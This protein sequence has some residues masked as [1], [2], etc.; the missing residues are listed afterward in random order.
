MNEAPTSARTAPAAW[1]VV[2][3]ALVLFAF[4]CALGVWQVQRLAWKEGLLAT[5]EERIHRPPVPFRD[6]L[7][8]HDDGQDI[9]YLPVSV[10]GTFLHSGE[11]HFFATWKGASGYFVYTPL[12]R[13]DGSAVFVNRG[14]VPFDR[15]PAATRGEGQLAGKVTVTGLA[16][17]RL[18]QK[19]SSILPDNEPAKNIFYWKD[20]EAMAATAGLPDGTGIVPFFVDADDSPNP[21]GLPAGGVTLISMPNNHLQYAVTWFGLAAALAGVVGVWLLRIRREDRPRRP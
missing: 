16:R 21:G 17:D 8:A 3:A 5:I 9:E 4:L 1:K 19:P 6:I 18:A 12:L 15:K 7:A 13:A 11:R 2:L 14:F 10:S 20:I